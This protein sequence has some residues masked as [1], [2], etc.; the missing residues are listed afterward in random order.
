[1]KF[2]VWFFRL[3]PVAYMI[4]IWIMSSL[5]HNALVELPDS[6][7]DRFLKESL[8]LVEFGILYV[9]LFLAGLTTN[10]FTPAVAY[11]MLVVAA[12][13][14]VVDEIHQSFVPYRSA[15]LIDVV[16]DVIGVL[17]AAHFMHHS[18]FSG[19]FVKLG[20]QLRRFEKWVRK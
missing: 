7:L 14:G 8:H 4:A 2:V 11:G 1:M 9:L 20:D 15:T 13:Y 12:L 6:G 10:R 18:Y 16:K 3:L 17:A 5:P 19:K